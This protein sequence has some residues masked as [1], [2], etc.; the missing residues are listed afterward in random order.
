MKKY[1]ERLTDKERE[2]II[3]ALWEYCERRKNALDYLTNDD[4]IAATKDE[5][6]AARLLYNAF[7]LG[8]K[9][10]EEASE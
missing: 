1:P 7:A 6:R 3:E 4:E 10:R 2:L 5:A 9:L 8:G